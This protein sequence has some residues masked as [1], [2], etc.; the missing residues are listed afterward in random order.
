[1]VSS[2]LK[3]FAPQ[4]LGQIKIACNQVSVYENPHFFYRYIQPN[5]ELVNSSNL[6]FNDKLFETYTVIDGEPA[7]QLF[8]S[9]MQDYIFQQPECLTKNI[10]TDPDQLLELLS[11]GT[12]DSNTILGEK[13]AIWFYESMMHNINSSD[14][15]IENYHDFYWWYMFN[16]TWA[17]I[18]IR[19]LDFHNDHNAESLKA[20]FDNF[21]HWFDTDD[22][23][24]WAMNNNKIGIKYGTGIGE[25][26]LV[27]K[28]YIYEFDQNEWYYKFKTKKNS[29]SRFNQKTNWDC[30]L[31]NFVE[32][33]LKD[34]RQE[35]LNLLPGHVI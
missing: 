19:N 24:Q 33:N 22:Y 35:I 4:D 3:N 16:I 25:Y 27:A 8:A 18:K 13:W 30:I 23:Q 29:V 1:M 10:R 21:V 11:S 7:D 28:Q 31:D 5:F 9:R 14:I 17:G 32:L 2:I 15:P 20:Y 34:H 26:K 6:K 12:F